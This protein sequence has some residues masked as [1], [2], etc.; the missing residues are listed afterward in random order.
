M[1]VARLELGSQSGFEAPCLHLRI[2]ACYVSTYV[3]ACHVCYVSTLQLT[4]MMTVRKRRRRRRRARV[5][6]GMQGPCTPGGACV[7]NMRQRQQQNHVLIRVRRSGLLPVTSHMWP[8]MHT[9]L[10]GQTS[11][12]CTQ[13]VVTASQQMWIFQLRLH[14]RKLKIARLTSLGLTFN[15]TCTD[16]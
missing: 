4:V 3:S 12:P 6:T 8:V 2:A 10:S 15:E 14:F 16:S 11:D 5:H 7:R 1:L 9:H 13:W